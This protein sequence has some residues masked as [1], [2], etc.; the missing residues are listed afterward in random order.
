MPACLAKVMALSIGL[1]AMSV[2]HKCL[3]KD[4]GWKWVDLA[5]SIGFRAMSCNNPVNYHTY[6]LIGSHTIGRSALGVPILV[7]LKY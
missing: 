4:V 3:C 5:P 2:S 7:H 6:R 1:R